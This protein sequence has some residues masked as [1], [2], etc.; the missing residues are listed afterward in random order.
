MMTDESTMMPKS[1]A[2]ID[3]RLADLPRRYSTAKANSRASGMLMATIKR[4][5][6]VAEEHQQDHG[7]QHHAHEQ[8]LADRFGGDV[9]QLG[10]VVIGLDL[11]ARQQPA[12]RVVQLVDLLLDVV[13]GRQRLL[14]LAQQHDALDLFVLVAPDDCPWHRAARCRRRPSSAGSCRRCP[15]ASDADHDALP[16]PIVFR[17]SAAA[18]PRRRRRRGSAGC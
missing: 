10:A 18:R 8:V 3:S 14:A 13:Q 4:R 11:H 5:A 9:D 2:P 17:A 7:H 12:R 6:D 15:A 16:C 1:T